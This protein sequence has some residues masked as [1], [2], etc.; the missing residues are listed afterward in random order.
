M[1][2]RPTEH[3]LY[4]LD[5]AFAEH[6]ENLHPQLGALLAC[7]PFKYA[8]KPRRL[9]GSVVYLFSEGDD[10]F[11]VGRSRKFSQ[12]LGN[13]CRPG[14]QANQS[15]FAYKLACQDIGFTPV[16]YKKGNSAIDCLKR[17]PGLSEAFEASKRRLAG[18]HIRYVEE[19]DDVRQA[20]LEIYAA[21]ALNTPHNTWKTS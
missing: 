6:A 18:M 2:L 12:R 9:P 11:Y 10:P 16:P 5:A 13:H 4:Q 20:L 8:M 19:K 14:S 17:E 15:S 3:R 21:V 7:P 1:T